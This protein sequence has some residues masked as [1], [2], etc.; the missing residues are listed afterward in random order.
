MAVNPS[1]LRVGVIITT[2]D[3]LRDL[4]RTLAALGDLVPSPDEIWV[5]ADGCTDGTV[6]WLSSECPG[7]RTIVHGESIGS[8]GSRNELGTSCG[9]EILLSLDD[10]SYPVESDFVERVRSLFANRPA[11]GVATFPQRSDEFPES[12]TKRNFGPPR[13]VASYVNSGAA[14]RQDVFH[15]LDGYP[16]FFFHAYEEPDFALRCAATGWQVLLDPSLTVRH[17]YTSAQRNEIRTHHRHSRNEL[18]S[19]FLRCPFPQLIAVTLFRIIRQAVYAKRRGLKWLLMEP[20]WWAATLAGLPLCFRERRPV[21]WGAYYQWMK[22]MRTPLAHDVDWTAQFGSP[23]NMH[24]NGTHRGPK[25]VEIG[26]R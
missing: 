15:A 10:D 7:V 8:V 20:L 3:R 24:S 22:L 11:L 9:C 18:W 16:A 17:H 6:E 19:V 21:R 13:Y 14:I 4:Q 25:A 12:L 1:P 26:A 5:C 2:R 23:A